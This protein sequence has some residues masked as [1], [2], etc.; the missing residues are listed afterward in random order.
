MAVIAA[1]ILASVR[2]VMENRT[3][4]RRQ[5]AITVRE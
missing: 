1:R 2:T 4:A 5:A 3:R